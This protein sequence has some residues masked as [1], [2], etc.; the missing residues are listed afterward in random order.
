MNK[1]KLIAIVLMCVCTGTLGFVFGTRTARVQAEVDEMSSH[2]CH[3][4][5]DLG[6]LRRHTYSDSRHLDQM[7]TSLDSLLCQ[8]ADRSSYS[9][10][11]PHAKRM[12]QMIRAYRSAYPFSGPTVVIPSWAP[13]MNT[14]AETYLSTVQKKESDLRY[15]HEKDDPKRSPPFASDILEQMEER[16]PG[17]ITV[18]P[19][20]STVRDLAGHYGG[21][22]DLSGKELYLFSDG[23]YTYTH[24]AD[25]VPET[26]CDMGTWTVTNGFVQLVSDRSLPERLMPRDQFYLPVQITGTNSVYILGSDASVSRLL[27]RQGPLTVRRFESVAFRRK[28][29][30]SAK[31]E[32]LLRKRLLKENWRPD[33][34]KRL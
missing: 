33:M 8:I 26:I 14:E 19:A 9:D 30:L 7:E 16:Y 24:W 3:V 12:L 15:S 10:L 32:V 22:R 6:Y 20:S 28:D 13:V 34:I 23:T 5:F 11:S 31:G 25:V 29:V 2:A 17:A 21:P 4:A 27:S 1:G 18:Q